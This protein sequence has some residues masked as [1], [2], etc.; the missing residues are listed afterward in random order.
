MS[1]VRVLHLDEPAP[2]DTPWDGVPARTPVR[3]L[4]G[5][6]AFGVDART[7]PPG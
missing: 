1:T 2:V 3:M 4:L 5:I 7:A 6:D